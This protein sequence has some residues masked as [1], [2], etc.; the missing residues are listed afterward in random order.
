MTLLAISSDFS[1]TGGL[2]NQMLPLTLMFIL[3]ACVILFYLL[4]REKKTLDKLMFLNLI[5]VQLT[6][7]MTVY[8][9]WKNSQMILDVSMTFSLMGFLATAVVL[10][11]LLKGGHQR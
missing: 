6:M 9:V 4:L 8:S 2:S 11:F 7:L 3:G 10:R 5:L 1:L